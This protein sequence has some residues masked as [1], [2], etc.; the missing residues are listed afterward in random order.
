[1]KFI[2]DI[3]LSVAS[4]VRGKEIQETG[5]TLELSMAVM[6]GKIFDRITT[7]TP[8]QHIL[9]SFD[10]HNATSFENYN[11]YR[12]VLFAVNPN[13]SSGVVTFPERF[14]ITPVQ[15]T[16]ALTKDL[17]RTVEAN[18]RVAGEAIDSSEGSGLSQIDIRKTPYESYIKNVNGTMLYY[19]W[20]VVTQ[21]PSG[22]F[23]RYEDITYG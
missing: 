9:N 7:Y 1:M 14:P 21:R 16:V 3:D 13:A 19:T 4:D 23:L 18:R 22:T 20:Y 17:A 6:L 15:S 10:I 8:R 2:N 12:D 5:D 11:S